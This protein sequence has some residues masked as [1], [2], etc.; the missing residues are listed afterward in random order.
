M[1]DRTSLA[2]KANLFRELHHGPEML[3]LPN[4]WDVA[5]AK[6][7]EA[8]GF[9][10]IATSSA[11]VAN[12][13]GYADGQ[14]IS[15]AEMLAA[16]ERIAEA[17][18]LPVS[19]DLEAGYGSGPEGAAELARGLILAGAV[20]LN[21]ED[22]TGN[23]VRPFKEIVQQVEEIRAIREAGKQAGVPL[24][25]NA[26]TDIYLEAK[27]DPAGWFAET[28]RRLTAYRDAGADCLFVPG[29]KDAAIIGALVREIRAP[30]NV[31]ALVGMPSLGELRQLGVKRV[32]F[33]SG[34]M[35]ACMGYLRK[36]LGRIQEA[37]TFEAILEGAI[38]YAELND[39]MTRRAAAA[40]Q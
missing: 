38:P 7:V 31:L 14:R 39:L 6:I 13:L 18:E 12:A 34:L 37:A 26:R 2:A 28:A 3:V 21:L 27:G 17:T 10:A 15:R 40:S 4:A 32:S 35:R 33:G 5:S 29:V 9:R 22:A 19:A 30:L 20:G 16:V 1:T 23:P 36:C 25:I 11:G 8:A 24:V